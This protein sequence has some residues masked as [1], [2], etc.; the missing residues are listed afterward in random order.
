LGS[1][2]ITFP[3][4]DLIFFSLQL[5]DAPSVQHSDT[6]QLPANAILLG[7]Q[8]AAFRAVSPIADFDSATTNY[9]SYIYNHYPSPDFQAPSWDSSRFLQLHHLVTSYA[10]R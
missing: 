2:A 4:F 9:I 10:Q 6:P 7:F 1:P 8:L 3:S 5:M